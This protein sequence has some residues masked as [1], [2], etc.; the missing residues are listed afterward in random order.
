[1]AVVTHMTKC[2]MA[3]QHV[4]TTVSQKIRSHDV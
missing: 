2:I 4:P 3:G 1:M